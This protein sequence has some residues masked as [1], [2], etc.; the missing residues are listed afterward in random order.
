M[1]VARIAFLIRPTTE[2]RMIMSIR[3]TNGFMYIDN[4]F[5]R[6]RTAN[7]PLRARYNTTIM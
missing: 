2:S 7:R 5:V 4:D 1:N 6:F 3:G